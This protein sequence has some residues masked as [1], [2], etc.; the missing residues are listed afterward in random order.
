[1]EKNLSLMPF[2]HRLCLFILP[3]KRQ[4]STMPTASDLIQTL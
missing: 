4:Y 3:F 1:M 2:S